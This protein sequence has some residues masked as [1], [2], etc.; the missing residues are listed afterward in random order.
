MDVSL[1]L[2]PFSTRELYVG[3]W[4]PGMYVL[5]MQLQGST[6]SLPFVIQR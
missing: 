1:A 6:I 5:T 3:H 4:A 2:D